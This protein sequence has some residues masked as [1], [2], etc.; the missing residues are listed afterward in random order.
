MCTLIYFCTGATPPST[1][2][3]FRLNDNIYLPGEAVLIDD[4]GSQPYVRSNSGSS[5]IC[6][7]ENVNRF[8]CRS[9]DGGNLGDWYYPNGSAVYRPYYLSYD[10]VRTGY[11]HQIRLA[12][13]AYYSAMDVL[14]LYTC[15]VPDSAGRKVRASINIGN[16]GKKIQLHSYYVFC[17][18]NPR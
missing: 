6:V 2:L 10:F 14:G 8:C 7:T 17:K 5:L 11:T 3:Y 13:S 15:E 16:E 18:S 9:S 1:G 12:R 4:I